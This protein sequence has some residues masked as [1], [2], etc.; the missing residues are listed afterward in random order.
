M[1]IK[2]ERIPVDDKLLRKKEAASLLACSAR[3]IDRLVNLGRLTRIKVMGGVRFRLS[4]V[5]Q[6]M[7]GGN[8]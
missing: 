6:I 3:T 7:Q 4:Q 1:Q 8:V 2:D 5:R